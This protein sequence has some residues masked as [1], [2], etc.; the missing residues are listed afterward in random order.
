MAKLIGSKE[1]ESSII[2]NL[3]TTF[4]LEKKSSTSTYKGTFIPN[5]DKTKLGI[6]AAGVG[7]LLFVLGLLIGAVANRD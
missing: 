7:A 1:A 5:S 3:G 6:F 4:L 2:S